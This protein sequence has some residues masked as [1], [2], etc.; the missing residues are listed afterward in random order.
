MCVFVHE[1]VAVKCSGEDPHENETMM[2]LK[3]KVGSLW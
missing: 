3:L 2:V 1:F